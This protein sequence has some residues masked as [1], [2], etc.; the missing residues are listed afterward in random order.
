MFGNA[1]DA[2]L[3]G[4]VAGDPSKQAPVF[5]P[6]NPS[7]SLSAGLPHFSTGYMRNWGRDT[8]VA[9]RGLLLIPRRFAEAAYVIRCYAACMRH[10]LIP[11]LL[12]GG[13]RPR[14]NSRDATWW[15][16]QAIQD[17]CLLNPAG[18]LDLLQTPIKRRYDGIVLPAPLQGAPNPPAEAAGRP[19]APFVGS[20][21]GQEVTLTDL[22]QEALQAHGMGIHFRELGAPGIDS[23]MRDEGFDVDIALDP[24]TGIVYGGGPWNCGT[25][26]DKMGDS[27]TAKNFG[28]PA[29]PRD[30]APIEIIGLLKS[31]LRWLL[32]LSPAQFRYGGVYVPDETGPGYTFLAYQAWDKV[33]QANFEKHFYIPTH[34][35]ED[36]AYLIASDLANKRG[37]YK[38][39]LEPTQPW[40]AYQLRPN[41][42]VAM[43]VAPELFVPHHVQGALQLIGQALKLPG[44]LGIATLDPEDWQYR[45]TYDQADT[46][47]YSTSCG[48][49]YHNGPEWLW[50]AGYYLRA[51]IRHTAPTATTFCP[52]P[53]SS[54]APPERPLVVPA[55]AAPLPRQLPAGPAAAAADGGDGGRVSVSPPITPSADPI[56]W[57]EFAQRALGRH[58]LAVRQCME[59]SPFKSLPELTNARG[60]TCHGSCQAQAWSSGCFLDALYDLAQ[61]AGEA[62]G[63]AAPA[64]R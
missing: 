49:S 56:A 32:T 13:N 55:S 47:D 63:M 46:A 30:G 52:S 12:D 58:I 44:S 45:P 39:V 38:D 51:L 36:P 23:K 35:R 34:P 3:L 20:A 33:L 22:I 54:V 27:H 59:W 61:A 62:T 8:F 42:C 10:G 31:S 21:A 43:T 50:M 25:W 53:A 6:T 1:F 37:F 60:A 16:L 41:Q 5:Q 24:S 57:E 15:W 7:P 14:F 29:T 2:P 64:D 9:L 11:N 26:M 19:G 40:H 48:F 18:A 17:Y 28:V 4:S